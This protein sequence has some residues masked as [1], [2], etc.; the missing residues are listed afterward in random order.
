MLQPMVCL[1]VCVYIYIYI[2]IY[3][4]PWSLNSH[5]AASLKPLFVAGIPQADIDVIWVQ[6]RCLVMER[7]SYSDTL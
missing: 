4:N 7:P 1:C 3:I 2:Y 5:D 6:T